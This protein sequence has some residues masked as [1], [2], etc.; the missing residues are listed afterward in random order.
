M[1]AQLSTS[2]ETLRSQNVIADRSDAD[3]TLYLV[4]HYVA[5]HEETTGAEDNATGIAIA[6][7]AAKAIANLDLAFNVRVLLVGGIDIG[8]RMYIDSMTEDQRAATVGVLNLDT[9]SAGRL[10][11]VGAG[12]LSALAGT[13]AEGLDI[14]YDSMDIH[15][16]FYSADEYF[17][18]EGF[19][20]LWI[21]AYI[22]R[23]GDKDRIEYVSPDNLVA[24]LE[25]VLGVVER[26]NEEYTQ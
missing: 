12:E 18:D 6:M 2:R 26:L 13:V 16:Q 1:T 8:T 15:P 23:E 24:A 17:N 4:A 7:Q 19:D 14:E 21:R 22:Q 25:I 10:E 11:L 5:Q 3:K 20:A 9:I